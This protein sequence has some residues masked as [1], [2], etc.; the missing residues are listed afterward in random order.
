MTAINSHAIRD[1][2]RDCAG[3]EGDCWIIY[4]G[5]NEVVGPYGAGTV[6]GRQAASLAFIRLD[7]ELKRSR[8]VQ[9]LGNMGGNRQVTEWRGME[10]FREHEVTSHDPKL[11]RVY[12]N[13]ERNMRA[14]IDAGARCG[15]N[16][17]VA[18]V[19]VNLRDC[20]PF[21]SKHRAG[22][23]ADQEREWTAHCE[24]GRKAEGQGRFAEA[25]SAYEQAAQFDAE[26][27]ELNYRRA[28]CQRALGQS[29]AA[30]ASYALARDLDTLR[31]RADSRLN[32]IVRRTA[33]SISAAFVDAEEEC[34][35]AAPGAVPGDEF[36]LDHVHLN[37]SGNFWLATLLLP[38]VERQLFGQTADANPVLRLSES[39]MARRL[40]FTDFDRGRVAEEMRARLRQPPFSEQSN[41]AERDGGLTRQLAVLTNSPASSLTNYVDAIRLA[42]NDWVLRAN[43]ARV[44]EAAGQET[45]AWA[46]WEQVTRLMP[47]EP[48]AFFQLGNLARNRGSLAE[49]EGWFEESLKR[50]PNTLEALNGLGLVARAEGRPAEAKRRFEAALAI[51]PRFFAARVNLA[52]L[53]AEAGNVAAAREQ[54]AAV[55]RAD[56]NNV[57]ARINLARL[58]ANAGDASQAARLYEEVL[59]LQPDN[60]IAHYNLANTLCTR[61]Q[62]AEGIL[63]YQA[64]VRA[65]PGFAEARYNLGLEL[66]RAGRIAEALDQF[67]EVV[68]LQPGSADA[69]F[70]YGVALARQLRHAEAVQEFRETLRLQPQHP[71]AQSLLER[72][73]RSSQGGGASKN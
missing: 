37:F 18:S 28:S 44:L 21:A 51:N 22:L 17:V 55:L 27:A 16:V 56:T 34:S 5:N 53:L 10:M 4:A 73:L 2:A 14:I 71:A 20:P 25:L 50:R 24:A 70:N 63:H 49:A 42:T 33:R 31:F 12:D 1:I 8:L 38:E 39:D 23:T 26:H 64:A 19:P 59:R 36:F 72:T 52:V 30:K 9:A 58:L 62:Y 11:R 29:N 47:H 45:N 67:A 40:A 66:A 32:E 65:N 3:A 46:Q 48:G 60:A 61:K 54:Y 7:L 43:L 41:Y 69:H 15:A 6:F 35:R 57:N 68:R 13:F